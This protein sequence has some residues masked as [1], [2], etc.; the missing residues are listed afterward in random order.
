MMLQGTSQSRGH[1][2]GQGMGR[3]GGESSVRAE[4]L[5]EHLAGDACDC[6][7]TVVK[8]ETW[9]TLGE[10][11]KLPSHCLHPGTQSEWVTQVAPTGGSRARHSPGQHSLCTPCAVRMEVMR[12]ISQDSAE[13]RH[14][15]SHGARAVLTFSPQ[16]LVTL[17][18]GCRLQQSGKLCLKW[19]EHTGPLCKAAGRWSWHRSGGELCFSSMG[20]GDRQDN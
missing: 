2:T 5:S 15:I 6:P 3:C 7:A 16:G 14:E 13:I 19:Q 12:C 1:G 10:G 11:G 20:R 9:K 17:G 4:F 18:W 8:G